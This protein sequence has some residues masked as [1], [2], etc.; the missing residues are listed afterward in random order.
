MRLHIHATLRNPEANWLC[1]RCYIDS[2]NSNEHYDMVM[3]ICKILTEKQEVIEILLPVRYRWEHRSSENTLHN[4]NWL[5]ASEILGQFWYEVVEN[6][7]LALVK[8]CVGEMEGLHCFVRTRA[9]QRAIT[10]NFN[11]RA[12]TA[13]SSAPIVRATHFYFARTQN[14]NHALGLWGVKRSAKP[15]ST[16]T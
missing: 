8:Y 14:I 12:R 13:V 1:A 4:C 6:C 9:A 16:I 5:Q 7:T 15:K 10:K 2:T 11:F 3:L